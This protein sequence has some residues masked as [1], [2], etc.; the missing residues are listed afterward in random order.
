MTHFN[1]DRRRFLAG[2]AAVAATVAAA[3]AATVAS[4]DLH[5]YAPQDQPVLDPHSDQFSPDTLFLL[6][7]WHTTTGLRQ[8]SL[9]DTFATM[10]QPCMTLSID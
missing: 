6:A 1:F 4:R 3:V 8:M 2:T 9:L 7:I 10:R 5:G